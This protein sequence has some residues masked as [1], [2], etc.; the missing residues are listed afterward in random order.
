MSLVQDD[1][2]VGMAEA[3]R[4]LK[5][6]SKNFKNLVAKVSCRIRGLGWISLNLPWLVLFC[7]QHPYDS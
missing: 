6:G 5:A 2:K 1:L 7:N 4:L 3:F